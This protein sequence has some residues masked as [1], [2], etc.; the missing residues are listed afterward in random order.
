M[1]TA[2]IT[3]E[4]SQDLEQAAEVA[5]RFELDAIE[6]RSVW[7]KLVH[8]LSG[9]ELQR[10]QDI[11]Q[12]YRL[13]VCAI[14]APVFKCSLDEEEIAAHILILKKTIKAAQKLGCRI[15]RGFSFWQDGDFETMLPRIAEAFQLPARMVEEAG[16]ELALELDPSVYACNGER[17]ARLV[18]TIAHPHI[19]IL[20]DAGNDIYSPIPEQ[21]FPEGYR[22][23]KPYI[24]HVHLKDAAKSGN[25]VES[26]KIG[27]GEVGWSEQLAALKRDR[28]EGYVS[29]E[30]HYRKGKP[31]TEELMR[32]PGGEAFSAC[33]R[34]ASEECLEV[35]QR[36][37]KELH[38]V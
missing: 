36:M 17:V 23:V 26:V 35:L 38:E 20:W 21:P 6:L 31:I 1:K 34:E 22:Y 28:Y 7:N 4:I 3:D 8:E 10:I 37:I 11:C 16:M 2:V 25:T 19:K 9:E 13:E 15:I 30:T 29:L 18:R 12:K 24:S 14:S 33:G 27:T 5:V 32:Q